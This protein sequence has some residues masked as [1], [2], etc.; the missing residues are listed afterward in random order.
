MNFTVEFDENPFF[1][2]TIFLCGVSTCSLE[3]YESTIACISLTDNRKYARS[4]LFKKK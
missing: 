1:T 3:Y 2:P 4:F